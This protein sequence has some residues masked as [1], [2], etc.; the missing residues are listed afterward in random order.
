LGVPLIAKGQVLGVLN[1]DSH[2]PG[3]F[4]DRD[5]EV[6]FTFANQAAV[7][8]ENA[9][10]YQ[11]SVA[12]VEREMEIAREIQSNLFPR[13]LPQINGMTIAARAVPARE[14]GGDFYDVV[15]L[16]RERFGL[17]IGDAS[18]KSIPGALLMAV[19][20]STARSEA[21]DHELPETVMRETNGLIASDVPPRSFVA[22]SYATL[23]V[24]TRILALSNAGQLSPLRRRRDGT[25]EYF[26]VPGP[27]LPLGIISDTPYAALEVPLEAGDL[28]VFYTDGIVEAHNA[29][30]E[31][32][33][34]ERLEQ[35]LRE[36]GH[37]APTE[38][39]DAILK[40]VEA[41]SHGVAQHDD[42]TLLVVRVEEA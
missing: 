22:L 31:L 40:E 23:D 13:H 27:V 29:R 21:R 9:R 33:G 14:T 11:E 5:M 1:I 16:G 24:D 38:L 12:R 25:V 8:L 2:T 36:N 17:L 26:D 15:P 10:L 35:L 7:A 6:A 32:F 34:F 4:S 18:G 19:A 30:Q 42:M 28:L 37:L 41:F 39:I 20:R 3:H